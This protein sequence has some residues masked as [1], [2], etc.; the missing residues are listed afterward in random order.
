MVMIHGCSFIKFGAKTMDRCT[1]AKRQSL[2]MPKPRSPKRRP[3]SSKKRETDI[4][5]HE[6]LPP[7]D[8]EVKRPCEWRPFSSE[9]MSLVYPQI[10]EFNVSDIFID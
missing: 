4:W 7:F 6:V 2:S 3:L 10:V 8:E 1:H 9:P 5:C